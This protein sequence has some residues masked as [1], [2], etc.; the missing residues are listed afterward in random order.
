MGFRWHEILVLEG[1]FDGSLGTLDSFIRTQQSHYQITSFCARL[2]AEHCPI[3]I[4]E[5]SFFNGS[6]DDLVCFKASTADILAIGRLAG[7]STHWM[8][9]F[10]PKVFPILTPNN[11][12][13]YHS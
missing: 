1:L 12:A 10:G 13:A 11:L 6:W 7:P 5:E 8:Q 2:M 9:P 4:N 3:E